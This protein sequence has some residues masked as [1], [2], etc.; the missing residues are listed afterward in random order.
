MAGRIIGSKPPLSGPKRQI[1]RVTATSPQKFTI[2]STACFGQWIHFYGNRSHECVAEKKQDC[3]G[4]LKA[5]PRKWKGYIHC[6]D[7]Q[8]QLASC[9]VELTPSA[10]EKLTVQVSES[11]PLRGLNVSIS[12]TKGGAKG[13]Y[14]ISL[15][16]RLTPDH[17]LPR[18]EDPLPILNFL[19]KCK[20]VSY[21]PQD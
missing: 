7:W 9:F 1:I 2:V 4:C 12:K 14:N 17:E 20:N 11:R 21:I 10:F 15:L 16:E 18:E 19:W 13:R 8:E 3:H 6:L 5:W